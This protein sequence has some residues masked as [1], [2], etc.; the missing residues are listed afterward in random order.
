[1]S[2]AVV[3]EPEGDPFHAPW[4]PRAHALTLAMGATG[5]WNLDMLRAARETLPDYRQLSYYEIWYGGLVKLLERHGLVTA[6]EIAAGRALGPARP[7]SRVLLA[8]QVWELL[9][10]GSPTL[11]EATR[12]A[13]FEVGDRVRARSEPPTGHTR[14]PAY[15]R[16][17]VGVIEF[18]RGAHV[19]PDAHAAGRGE[20]PE[21]LYGVVFTAAELWGEDAGAA[22]QSVAI[23][24]WEPYLEP[25]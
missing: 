25:A 15:A 18:V 19:Y 5:V 10:R 11:R 3:P 7:V 9:R 1:V 21:W 17:H 2:L 6:D 22:G 20:A 16:G 24:A 23:D 4:E 14:L 12:P 13:R 8:P